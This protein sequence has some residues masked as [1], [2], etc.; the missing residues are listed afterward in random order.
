[1]MFQNIAA[2]LKAMGL[3][4]EAYHAGLNAQHLARVHVG[5]LRG[6][7]SVVVATVAFGMGINKADVRNVIH[8]GWPQSLEQY[9]QAS[10][11]CMCKIC[12]CVHH[13]N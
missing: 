3:A 4:A 9:F 12:S 11:T 6:E 8:Y 5:F 10:F 7:I 1:M 2:K 13:A